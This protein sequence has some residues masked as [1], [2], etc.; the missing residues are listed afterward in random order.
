LKEIRVHPEKCSGCLCCQLACSLAYDKKF[1][2]LKARIIINWIGEIDRG[3]SFT[4]SCNK[5]CLCVQYCNFGALEEVGV[6]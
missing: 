6:P 2:P 3:I 1:N 4:D 5:C